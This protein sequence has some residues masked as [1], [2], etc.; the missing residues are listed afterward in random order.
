MMNENTETDGDPCHRQPPVS[1]QCNGSV[2][3]N[4]LPSSG[5]VLPHDLQSSQDVTLSVSHLSAKWTDVSGCCDVH[6]SE[7][8]SI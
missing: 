1:P 2:L 5:N 3:P 7:P 4:D 6:R 8:E